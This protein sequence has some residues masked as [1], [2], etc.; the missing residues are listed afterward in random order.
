VDDSQVYV[1][2]RSHQRQCRSNTVECYNV[3]CCF[4]SVER[5]F[6]I[7]ASVDRATPA[8]DATAAVA[9]I[10]AAIADTNDW[11]KAS[12]PRLTPSKT[13]AMWLD[14]KRQL[15]KITIKDVPL[16][17][18]VFTVVESARDLGITSDSK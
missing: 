4:D 13:Q 7:V 8:N 5:C 18:T 17:S 2:P 11:K 12:R 14:T 3:E 9:R 16:L 15:D 1:K 6:D 10:S